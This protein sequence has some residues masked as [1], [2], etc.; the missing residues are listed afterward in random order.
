MGGQSVIK[1]TMYLVMPGIK[2]SSRKIFFQINEVMNQSKNPEFLESFLFLNS[3]NTQRYLT[4]GQAKMTGFNP[5]NECADFWSAAHSY[6]F[7][8]RVK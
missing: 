3:Q 2:D 4:K 6:N 8:I 1:S 5:T 7:I